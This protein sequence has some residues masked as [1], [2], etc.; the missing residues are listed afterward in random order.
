[1]VNQRDRNLVSLNSRSVLTISVHWG[2]VPLCSNPFNVLWWLA[3]TP[4]TLLV[5][6]LIAGGRRRAREQVFRVKFKPFLVNH[7][8]MV[9][10]VLVVP[11]VPLLL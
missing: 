3:W 1:M 4:A 5:F 7:F 11:V 8:V 2:I 9:T 10:N 6:T